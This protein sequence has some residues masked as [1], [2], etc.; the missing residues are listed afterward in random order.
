MTSL[1]INMPNHCKMKDLCD[2]VVRENLNL[3]EYVPDELKTKRMCEKDI[4]GVTWRFNFTPEILRK[5]A[6]HENAVS[7]LVVATCDKLSSRLESIRETVNFYY[8]KNKDWLI[9]QRTL[10]DELEAQAK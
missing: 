10:H 9:Q 3:F 2:Y 8:K 6:M 5:Q 1:S 4:V 7:A